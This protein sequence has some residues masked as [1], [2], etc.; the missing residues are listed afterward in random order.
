MAT[1]VKYF[2]NGSN[3]GPNGILNDGINVPEYLYLL[4]KKFFGYVNTVP[5]LSFIGEDVPTFAYSVPNGF[6]YL[7]QKKLYAQI[8]PLSNPMFDT[9]R[10]LLKPEAMFRDYSF[11]NYN[12]FYFNKNMNNDSLSSKYISKDY[13]YIAFYSNLLLTN[14]SIRERTQDID[15]TIKSL[16]SNFDTT[17]VHSLLQQSISVNYDGSYAYSL[18]Q[19]NGIEQIYPDNGYS[20]VDTDVGSI[21]F[22]DRIT[23]GQQISS[24]NPPRISFFRYEG[25]FGEANILSSQEF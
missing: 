15:G 14:I 20:L 5:D 6:P 13:P 11:S 24:S 8:V 9:N 18:Y 17:Y 10:F 4:S 22:Y 12:Y 19:S 1:D 16:Y 2:F 3:I 23:S 21:N 7:H 25:L